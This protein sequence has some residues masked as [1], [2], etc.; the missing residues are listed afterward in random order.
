ML[1]EDEL[2]LLDAI[3]ETGSSSRAAA[4]LGKA[5]S[6]VSYAA[7]QLETRFDALLFDRRRYRLQPTPAGQL[8][9][10]EAARLLLD[11]ARMTQRGAADRER[12][13]GSSVGDRGRDSRIRIADAC[14]AR[15]RCAPLRRQAAFHARSAG[16]HVGGVA[17][18]AKR[19]VRGVDITIG[20]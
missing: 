12:L 9:A 5:P 14:G 10:D 20:G 11:M 3:R 19:L 4:R 18:L 15:L 1:S 17:R 16:R 2:V 13:G 7:R 6:T 8:L